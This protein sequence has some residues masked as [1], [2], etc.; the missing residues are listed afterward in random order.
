MANGFGSLYVGASSLQNSQNALNTTANNLA[1]VDTKGYVRQQVLFADRDYLNIGDTANNR[2]QIGL[3][4]NILDGVH[5]RDY[6]LDRYYRTENGRQSFYEASGEV[7]DGLI[8][9]YQELE[10]ERFQET[11]ENVFKAFQELEKGPETA[12]NHN[13]VTQKS[14]LFL[15]RVTEMYGDMKEY[16]DKVNVKINQTIDRI[17]QLGHK[18]LNLNREIMRVESG[19]IETAMTLR[20][21]RDNVLDE[22]SSLAK[23]DFSENPDGSVRVKLENV[24]FV[25]ELNIYEMYGMEDE[26]TGFITPIWPQLSD[27]ERG[28]YNDVFNFTVDISAELN[29][30]IGRLKALVLARGDRT[31]TYRDVLGLSADAF[32]DGVGMSVMMEGQAELDQMVHKMVTAINDILSPTKV[33]TFTGLDGTY[34][35]NAR[36]WDEE[37]ACLGADGEKPGQ[38]LFSRRGC[39]RYTKVQSTDGQIYYVYNEESTTDTSKMY[40]I[41]G[42]VINP[43]LLEEESRL[44][45]LKQ[46]GEPAW[47]EIAEKIVDVWQAKDHIVNANNTAPCNFEGYYERMIVELSSKG[48]VYNTLATN[49]TSEVSSIDNNRQQVIGVSSDEELTNMI[50]YQNAYNAASRYINVVSEMLEHL[51]TRL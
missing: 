28:R 25:D 18:I 35:H 40:C 36:V 19:G 29:T 51:V 12:L 4:L 41:D 30:D 24:E 10:G 45:H 37:N 42:L 46:N 3:G 33:V 16:Q 47:N 14:T 34:Y 13:L 21:E 50:K 38:E 9:V 26:N 2:Q 23:V 44:P 6:F 15:Q 1:N 31:G 22:L 39:D 49:L 7:V 11:M 48:S 17:N 20:D 27:M 5:T 32:N 8:D 43:A